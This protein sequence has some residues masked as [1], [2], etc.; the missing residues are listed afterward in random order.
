MA[1]PLLSVYK[2]LTRYGSGVLVP[3]EFNDTCSCLVNIL[4]QGPLEVDATAISLCGANA[5]NLVTTFT[6]SP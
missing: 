4:V 5:L 1:Y 3:N 2:E 6:G